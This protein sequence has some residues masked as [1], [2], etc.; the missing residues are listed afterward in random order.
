MIKK[1]LRG[2]DHAKTVQ[3]LGIAADETKR[4]ARLEGTNKISLLAKYGYTEKMAFELCEKYGLLSPIYDFA[5]RGAVGSARMQDTLNLNTLE[6]TTRTCG[7]DFW[8]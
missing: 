6:P 4:L 1:F 3:Y 2:K 5:P 8:T 7:Q